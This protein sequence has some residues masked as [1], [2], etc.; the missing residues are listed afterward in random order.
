MLTNS[1]EFASFS[2]SPTLVK[3]TE[4]LK[5]VNLS[6]KRL[7]SFFSSTNLPKEARFFSTR[8]EV[9]SSDEELRFEGNKLYIPMDFQNYELKLLLKSP[10]FGVSTA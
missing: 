9:V 1:T 6:L 7:V 5:A 10:S 3:G 2:V 4:E 8:V